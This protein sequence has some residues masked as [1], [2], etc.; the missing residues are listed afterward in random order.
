M[1]DFLLYLYSMIEIPCF[2]CAAHGANDLEPFF[3]AT[4]AW[5]KTLLTQR[6]PN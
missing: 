3:A 1:G 6:V 4:C 2:I 5:Q